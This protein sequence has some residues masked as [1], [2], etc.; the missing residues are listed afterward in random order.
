MVFL[1]VGTQKQDFSRLFKL[2]ENSKAL[3]DEEIIAASW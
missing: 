2:V 1:A 3:K